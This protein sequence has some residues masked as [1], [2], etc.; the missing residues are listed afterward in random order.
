MTL[1]TPMTSRHKMLDNSDRSDDDDRLL[2]SCGKEIVKRAA[3]RE[4][5]CLIVYVLYVDIFW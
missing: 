4:V 5:N 2:D 3:S 1:G